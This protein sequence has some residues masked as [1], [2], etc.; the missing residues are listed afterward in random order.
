[1]SY[2]AAFRQAVEEIKALDPAAVAAN[3]GAEYE[4]GCFK[5]TFFNR[6]FLIRCPDITVAEP[7]S[8]ESPAVWLQLALLHYLTRSGRAP[9]DA[10]HASGDQWIAY[11][12]LPG[13]LSAGGV[14]QQ[15]AI[16]PMVQTFGADLEGF[17]QACLSMGGRPLSISGD[18]AFRF[19]ALPRIPM[20]AV[21][22][23]GE[24]GM[25][26]SGNI[27]FGAETSIYLPTEDLIL[28]GEYLSAALQGYKG[29]QSP[30]S[31]YLF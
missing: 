26:A 5:L 25:P 6:A 24:E 22:Y 29:I 16:T 4:S 2:E 8:G 7:G 31:T 9:G 11:R 10:E 19:A 20:A 17:K 14:F 30:S 13:A 1:M 12:Q 28:I 21:L 23:L 3:S 15:T 18:A 27:L